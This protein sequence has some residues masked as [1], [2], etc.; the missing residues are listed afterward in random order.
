MIYTEISE[1]FDIATVNQLYNSV[2]EAVNR[3]DFKFDVFINDT[4]YVRIYLITKCSFFGNLLFDQ[5]I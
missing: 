3:R 5:F 1:K 4:A 2:K